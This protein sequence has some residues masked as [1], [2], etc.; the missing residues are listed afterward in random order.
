MCTNH[1]YGLVYQFPR[2]ETSG[3][4]PHIEYDFGIGMFVDIAFGYFLL[5]IGA[6]L[7]IWKQL[8][9]SRFYY[10]Q[11]AA[12]LTSMILPLISHLIWFAN[13]LPFPAIDLTPIFFSGSALLFT[14]AVF[15][16]GHSNF[17]VLFQ[18]HVIM[19]N[20]ILIYFPPQSQHM[21]VVNSH[22]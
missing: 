19:D 14:W 10:A 11:T 16:Q 1:L 8:H 9:M 22:W 3:P 20:N 13:V 21:T 12:I 4:F 7:I 18:W 5:G 17:T 6:I 15:S 2:I